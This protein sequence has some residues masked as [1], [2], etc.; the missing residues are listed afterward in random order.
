MRL[1]GLLLRRGV[2]DRLPYASS[3]S[4]RVQADQAARLRGRDERLL[5][6][7][8]V[9]HGGDQAGHTHPPVECRVAAAC[10]DLVIQGQ[11]GVDLVG[12]N[13]DH[14]QGGQPGASRRRP[15]RPEPVDRGSR[16]TG[17]LLCQFGV[18]AA[19]VPEQAF[20][21]RSPPG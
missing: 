17:I 5:L 16:S 14:H 11:Q 15:Q 8:L 13:A 21:L 3:E 12:V 9:L 1:V 18:S 20:H 10:R 19:D 6:P 7:G 2:R 4:A